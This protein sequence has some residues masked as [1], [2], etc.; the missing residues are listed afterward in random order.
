MSIV[1][2]SD[3]AL[4]VSVENTTPA[5][6]AYSKLFSGDDFKRPQR[7]ISQPHMYKIAF[8]SLGAESNNCETTMLKG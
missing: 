4:E 3:G 2:V 7:E 8:L 1:S 5:M 6:A